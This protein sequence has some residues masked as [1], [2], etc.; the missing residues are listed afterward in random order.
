MHQDSF[1]SLFR[2][3][4]TLTATHHQLEGV[5]SESHTWSEIEILTLASSG[6][7]SLDWMLH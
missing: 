6:W 4:C 1:L 3:V 5:W 2:G 7:K